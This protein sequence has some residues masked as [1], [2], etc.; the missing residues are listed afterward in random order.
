MDAGPPSSDPAIA[1]SATEAAF[2]GQLRVTTWLAAASALA[3]VIPWLARV[4]SGSPVRLLAATA[5]T[6]GLIGLPCAV[7]AAIRVRLVQQLLVV[8]PW[9]CRW[10]EFRVDPVHGFGRRVEVLVR[11]GGRPLLDGVTK[12]RRL[13]RRARVIAEATDGMW[14][15]CS[16]ATGTFVLSPMGGEVLVPAR[17]LRS[18]L[19]AQRTRRRFS[20]RPAG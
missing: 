11:D 12:G 8:Q 4:P 20:P 19:F 17:R 2:R 6:A 15:V 7:V 5:V 9:V 18:G 1:T 10:V 13:D 3:I 14:W 16:D